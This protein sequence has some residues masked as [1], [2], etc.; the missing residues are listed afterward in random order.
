MVKKRKR[1]TLEQIVK[2]LRDDFAF[3][4]DFLFSC[5]GVAHTIPFRV[6]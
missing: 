6:V 5:P 4:R 1:H 3:N 2:K